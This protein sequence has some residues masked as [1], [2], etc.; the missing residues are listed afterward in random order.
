MTQQFSE[1]A[2]NEAANGMTLNTIKLH[3]GDVGADGTSNQIAGASAAAT[4]GSAANSERD[5][6]ESVEVNVPADSVVSHYSVWDGT[7]FKYGNVFDSEPET[8][9][10]AGIAVVASAKVTLVNGG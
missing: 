2:L 10:N 9:A 5:L 8:Y 4:Y 3:N 6:S 7:T 1:S